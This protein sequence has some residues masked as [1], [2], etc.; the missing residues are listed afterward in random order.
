MYSP[1]DKS[2]AQW[3][4]S[5]RS[6]APAGTSS[7]PR[8]AIWQDTTVRPANA[9]ELRDQW[10]NVW[11][12][13]QTPSRTESLGGGTTLSVYDDA[14]GRSA[15]EVYTV[16]GMGHGLA[17]D[18]GSGTEQCGSAGTYYLDT[19]CSSYHTARF[20]GLDGDE[21][22]D[23]PHTDTGL[24]AGTTYSYAAA[25]VDTTA[26]AGSASPAV[27]ATTTGFAPT[28]HTAGNYAHTAAGRAYQSG[29][30]AYAKGSGEAMGLWNTFTSH[31]LRQTAP[32]H[33]VIVDAGCPN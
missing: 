9:T 16:S 29:G 17:V 32:G 28:C 13:G 30:Y 19:I 26:A 22:A 24:D 11:G 23:S 1:P 25:A 27:A 18:P 3:G 31:P 5:V 12:I 4:E 7:W 15:V 10:T 2:P 33:Y 14:S 6:A 8:V 20:W 21:D